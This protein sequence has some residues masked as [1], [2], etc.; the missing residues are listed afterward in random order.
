MNFQPKTEQEIIDSK[1]LKK[2]VY[3]FEVEQATEKTSKAGHSMFEVRLKLN[4]S[5]RVLTD[6]LLPEVPEKFRHAA[7]ACGLL[8]QYESGSLS[9]S[10]LQGKRGKLKLGI[11]KGKNGYP[12]RN[13]VEDYLAPS[14]L[15]V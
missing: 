6:Y 5:G 7:A 15:L 10:D 14:G 4:G 13:K 3:E 11:E 2:G 12:P 1:L 8:A 9:D